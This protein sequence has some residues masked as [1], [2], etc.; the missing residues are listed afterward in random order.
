MTQPRRQAH[1]KTTLVKSIE[2]VRGET[3]PVPNAHAWATYRETFVTKKG[4]ELVGIAH[5]GED[6]VLYVA[7][8]RGR[9]YRVVI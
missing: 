2:I 1:E 4:G 5:S 9:K 8:G 3:L 6:E 7:D